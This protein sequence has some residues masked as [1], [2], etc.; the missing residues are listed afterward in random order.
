MV[1]HKLHM[2]TSGTRLLSVYENSPKYRRKSG[3]YA[4]ASNPSLSARIKKP[5][6]RGKHRN[7]GFS[8]TYIKLN[9]FLA[10]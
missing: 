9:F 3:G 1:Q 8:V 2:H 10:A 4:D 6:F 5:V 7:T